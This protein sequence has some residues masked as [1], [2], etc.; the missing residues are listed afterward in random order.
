MKGRF[1]I[2]W[3]MICVCMAS[4]ATVRPR[5]RKAGS[6]GSAQRYCA[7]WNE[8]QRRSASQMEAP[9]YAFGV[10]RIPVVLVEFADLAF[11]V[12]EDGGNTNEFYYRFCNGTLD[13]NLYK[14][15]GSY[16][17]V[18][19]YFVQQSD[20]LFLPEFVIIGPV[21]L[22]ESYAYYGKN[23]GSTHDVNRNAFVSQ[24][25]QKAQEQFA[26]WSLFDNDKDGVV[27]MIYFIYAGE[28]ENGC[29]DENTIWPH[30]VVSER[31]IAN[32]TF[33]S[34][35]CCNELYDGKADGVGV[36]CHELCHA[37]GL[38][39][40]YDTKGKGYGLDYWDIMDTGCYCGD[41][42]H[43]CGLSAYEKDFMGWRRIVEL[44]RNEE[45]TLN[46]KPIGEGGMGYKMTNPDNRYEY[47]I[48]ENRQN[49]GWDE[50]IG[51]GDETQKRHGMLISHVDYSTSRW[52]FNNVN[53]VL[54]HQCMTIIPADGDLYSYT[55]VETAEDTRM[56]S[57]SADG[58]LFPGSEGV[59]CLFADRQPVFTASGSMHQ[60][61]T[62][63]C[64]HAD[65]TV[66]LTVCCFADVNGDGA[67]DTQ[68][69]LEIY[70]YIRT[71]T[72]TEP[73]VR[74]DVNDDR[75]VDSQDVLKVYD[76]MVGN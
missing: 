23:S 48:L 19:D 34:Y 10:Q 28:G 4:M 13:G 62:N 31:T 7:P 38:P 33:G 11:S 12:T 42:Y 43:P 20:S 26:D 73:R 3:C 37:L 66:T 76:Y 53:T 57:L 25:V 46:L 24:A 44:T 65:G 71:Q 64:E 68:D 60:P 55:L 1:V 49:T 45:E 22:P 9:L 8:P 5:I 70:E 18:R 15:A 2:L 36:M 14:G 56:W 29:K 32:V 27:D 17:S 69:I 58:D 16:G 59:T 61:L 39:D 72:T 40:F 52:S 41:G 74:Q 54:D 47:Y 67:V 75:I 35:G 30:E 21:V 63:I 50:L 6:E 51:R